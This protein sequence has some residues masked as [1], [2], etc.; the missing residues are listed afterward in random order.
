MPV[1]LIDA[2]IVAYRA[3]SVSGSEF[4][5]DSE[6]FDATQSACS[7][8]DAIEAAQH[9]ITEWTTNARCEEAV[10][11]FS[12]PAPRSSFRYALM[13]SY[14]SNRKGEKP[15]QYWP[16]IEALR[17]EYKCLTHT[18]LEADDVMGFYA[19]REPDRYTIVSMDKDMLT[20]PARVFLPHKMQRPTRISPFA[21]FVAWMTQTLTGDVT[22]CY[23]G[24]P[25]IGPKRAQRLIEDGEG[26]QHR[27]WSSVVEAFE[28]K[29]KTFADA[30]ANARC[31][32]ILR[33]TDFNIDTGEIRLWHPTAPEWV[34]PSKLPA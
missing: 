34:H 33:K 11:C 1:A 26:D 21:A 19:T 16:L 31:A 8:D 22:D 29:E 7:L 20:V 2:D 27:I 17:T 12:D 28:A 5:W 9:I 4:D 14:K 24:C 15:E 13:P 3:S 30:L 32:R 18:R 25:G 10:L 6:G 23:P